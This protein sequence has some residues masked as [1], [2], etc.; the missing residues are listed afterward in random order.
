LELRLITEEN[1]PMKSLKNHQTI[2]TDKTEIVD[3]GQGVRSERDER[4]GNDH[5]Y[6]KLLREFKALQS[7]LSTAKSEFEEDM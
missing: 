5:R 1:S 7:T 6:Q 3:I 2:T 4:F